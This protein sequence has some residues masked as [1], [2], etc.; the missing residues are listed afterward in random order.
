MIHNNIYKLL[1]TEIIPKDTLN[2]FNFYSLQKLYII[3]NC[4]P[5]KYCSKHS[6]K[7]ELNLYKNRFLT[8]WY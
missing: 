3:C 6:A 5:P 8:L 7:V 1:N 4:P 2:N